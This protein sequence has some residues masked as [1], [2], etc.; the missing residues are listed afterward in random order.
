MAIQVTG[1]FKNPQTQQLFS[2]PKLEM[3]PHLSYRGQI[4][5]QVDITS[6]FN[7]SIS[8]EDIDK[9]QLIYNEEITDPYTQIIDA[10]EDYVIEKLSPFNPECIFIK[11]GEITQEENLEEN[12]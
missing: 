10:L 1:L 4:K 5:L 12:E 7:G 9:N 2:N 11:D 3:N 6:D 8:Y